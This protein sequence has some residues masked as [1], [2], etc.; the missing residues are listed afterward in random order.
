MKDSSRSKKKFNTKTKLVAAAAAAAAFT[1]LRHDVSV[2]VCNVRQ[3][4]IETE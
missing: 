3:Q 2:N 4:R 1:Y